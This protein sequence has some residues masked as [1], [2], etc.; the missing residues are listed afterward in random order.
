MKLDTSIYKNKT[1]G[2]IIILIITLPLYFNVVQPALATIHPMFE[3]QATTTPSK[4]PNSPATILYLV[5]VLICHIIYTI[6]FVDIDRE[7]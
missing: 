4:Y 6:K 1:A 5:I 2:F 3:F 7:E